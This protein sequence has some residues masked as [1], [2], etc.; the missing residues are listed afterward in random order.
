M[1]SGNPSV[2]QAWCGN[3]NSL[4]VLERWCT[5]WDLP[6]HRWIVQSHLSTFS[7]LWN[8]VINYFSEVT[9]P[10]DTDNSH[11]LWHWVALTYQHTKNCSPKVPHPPT[12][13]SPCPPPEEL[14]SLHPAPWP[15]VGV[16]RA[17]CWLAKR[18]HE[19][20]N[21]LFLIYTELA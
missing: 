13:E 5:S 16:V 10:S 1:K 6:D 3:G 4:G 17:S 19:A 20:L 9:L 8:T 11:S 12:P 15:R 21:P 14:P 18:Q 7:C 2:A